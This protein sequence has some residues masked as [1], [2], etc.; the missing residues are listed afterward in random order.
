[1][2]WCILYLASPCHAK[3]VCQKEEEITRK[4]FRINFPINVRITLSLP[5]PS[6]ISLSSIRG[7]RLF[8]RGKK[9]HLSGDNNKNAR[10]DANPSIIRAMR[11]SCSANSNG[12]AA[13]SRVP[14]G[15]V[16]RLD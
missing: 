12:A 14:L 2:V 1:M 7:E 11:R 13:L 15:Q 6:V 16:P 4:W 10:L 9:M 5:I 8:Y 3:K